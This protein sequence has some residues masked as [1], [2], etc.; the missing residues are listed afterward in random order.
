MK[1]INQPIHISNK[2]IKRHVIHSDIMSLGPI[3]VLDILSHIRSHDIG[4]KTSRNPNL[5]SQ[6]CLP[7]SR[8]PFSS[9]MPATLGFEPVFQT[10]VTA[11]NGM[12]S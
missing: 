6:A 12:I 10:Q 4:M 11:Q 8:E 9:V 2:T 3:D 5:L 1:H 7:V